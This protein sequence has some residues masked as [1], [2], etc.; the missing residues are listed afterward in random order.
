MPLGKAQEF[1]FYRSSVPNLGTRDCDHFAPGGE[2]QRSFDVSFTLV[3]RFLS[4]LYFSSWFTVLRIGIRTDCA[5]SKG[6]KSVLINR[7]QEYEESRVA[8]SSQPVTLE[9]PAASRNASSS[10]TTPQAISPGIPPVSQRASASVKPNFFS[11]KLPDLSQDG[12]DAP[13]QAV[14][15]SLFPYALLSTRSMWRF[16]PWV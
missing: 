1:C 15:F 2:K 12:P 10:A 13:V 8:P 3:F 7:I 16:D 9:T 4:G 11:V 6:N 5:I 14:S